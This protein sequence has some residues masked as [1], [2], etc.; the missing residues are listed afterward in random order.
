[1]VFHAYNISNQFSAFDRCGGSVARAFAS[2]AGYQGLI[3]GRHRRK[4]LKKARYSSI[5]KC[6]ATDVSV[7]ENHNEQMP[8]VTVCRA[9]S[10]C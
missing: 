9:L 2:Q 3:P 6:L 1:M 10:Y 7:I 5:A 4:L 8:C